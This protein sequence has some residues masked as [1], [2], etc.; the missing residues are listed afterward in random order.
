MLIAF[1]AGTV[2]IY[3][4]SETIEADFNPRAFVNVH[5]FKNHDDAIDYIKKIDEND[6]YYE[7]TVNQPKFTGGVLPDYLLYNNFLNWFEA[8]VSKKVHKRK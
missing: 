1:L 2:P 8:V 6:E 3:W 7:W 5:N 4:G